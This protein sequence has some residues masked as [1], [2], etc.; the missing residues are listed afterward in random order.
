MT[1]LLCHLLAQ[2]QYLSHQQGTVT[3]QLPHS[4]TKTLKG[5]KI[6]TYH[7]CP[8]PRI[9]ISQLSHPVAER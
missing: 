9:H 7:F 5:Y 6:G 4:L 3:Y 8:S 1:N 2:E